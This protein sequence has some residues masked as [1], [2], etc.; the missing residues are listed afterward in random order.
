MQKGPWPE[1]EQRG[2]DRRIPAALV[3]GG[4]GG[5]AVELPGTKR[6][7]L[8]GLGRGGGG[9][10]RLVDG[11]QRRSAYEIGG[12]GV[13][14]EDRRRGV[15]VVAEPPKLSRLK[16]AG[17]HHKGNIS[18]NA[19][20]TGQFLGLSGNVPIQPPILGSKSIPRTKASPE[21][22]QPQ[23]L[24]HRHSKDYK[25]VQKIITKPT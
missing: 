15:V 5:G 8:V 7:L 17:H 19:L 12:E 11:E 21:I 14:V 4:E 18:L 20:Q 10:K 2:V 6:Y 1:S 24:Q 13:L 23:V 9:R 25:P 16:C 22:L 3:I